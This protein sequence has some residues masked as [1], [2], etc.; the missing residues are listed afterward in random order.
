MPHLSGPGSP[1]LLTCPASLLLPLLL[2]PL[3][4]INT[5]T[6]T[7]IS[8][9]H[10]ASLCLLLVL[11][12]LAISTAQQDL[13]NTQQYHQSHGGLPME[14]GCCPKFVTAAN[15]ANIIIII[16]KPT[17]PPPRPSLHR[18]TTPA[19]LTLTLLHLVP[20]TAAAPLTSPQLTA[21]ATTDC[22]Y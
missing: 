1:H 19:H 12:L 22:L 9:P 6:I 20:T 16:I 10:R 14:R 3:S 2:L 7:S 15:T 13:I 17:P 21:T 4:S 8:S 11:A 18:L 5:N